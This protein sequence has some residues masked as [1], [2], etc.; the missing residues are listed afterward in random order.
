MET[1]QPL[2]VSEEPSPVPE[3]SVTTT[4]T[5]TTSTVQSGGPGWLHTHIRNLILLALTAVVCY[6]ALMGDTQAQ[7]AI[8]ATFISLAS[9]KF[10]ENAALKTPGK[11][12]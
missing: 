7:A 10:G 8:I 11:D 1:P 12:H 5:D 3:T 4:T 2:P 6:L 9:Y